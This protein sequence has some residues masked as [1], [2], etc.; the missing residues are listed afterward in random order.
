MDFQQYKEPG[1]A[2]PTRPE[3]AHNDFL[4]LASD[5]GLVGFLIVVSVFVGFWRHALA[6]SKPGRPPEEQ[7]FAIV[8]WLR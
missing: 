7:A 2:L 8:P 3:Y 6:V 5:Y 1:P 4:N